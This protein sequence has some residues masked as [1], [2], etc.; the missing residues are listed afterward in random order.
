M[1]CPIITLIFNGP[2]ST[3][4]WGKLKDY[5]RNIIYHSVASKKHMSQ[6]STDITLGWKMENVIL[7]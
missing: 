1:L 3:I 4:K 5:T 2:N 7:K 6:A